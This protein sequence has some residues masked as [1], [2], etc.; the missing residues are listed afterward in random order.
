LMIHL[1]SSSSLKIFADLELF[2]ISIFKISAVFSRTKRWS[3]LVI[4]V[5]A[6]KPKCRQRFISLRRER[7]KWLSNRQECRQGNEHTKPLHSAMIDNHICSISYSI[8][9]CRDFA[10]SLPTPFLC[11]I[12]QNPANGLFLPSQ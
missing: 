1:K 11:A 5:S 7:F 8:S 12:R 9:H 6:D 2:D 10:G 4:T 3:V